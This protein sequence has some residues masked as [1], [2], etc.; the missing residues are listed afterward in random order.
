MQ[1]WQLRFRWRS[2]ADPCNALVVGSLPKLSRHSHGGAG[3]STIGMEARSW[4]GKSGK[5]PDMPERQEQEYGRMLAED[6]GRTER[7]LIPGW[8]EGTGDE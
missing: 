1:L 8:I 3:A 5:Y 4:T 7:R 6:P 2:R